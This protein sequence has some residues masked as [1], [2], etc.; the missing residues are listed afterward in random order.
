MAVLGACVGSFLNVVIYRVPAGKSVVYPGSA[1]TCGRPIAWYDNIPVISWLLLRGRARCCGRTFSFRY[2]AIE[3]L[4]AGLFLACWLHFAPAKA[5]CGW[6]LLS[7]LVAGSCID[8][9]HMIIPDRF[10]LGL[11]GVG[12]VLAVLV[13]SLHGFHSGQAVFDGARSLSVALQGLL[14]GS[15]IVLWLAL[16][17]EAVLKRE[18][19]GIG[20]VKLLGAIGVFCGWAGAAFALGAGAVIGLLWVLLSLIWKRVTGKDSALAP[21]AK[22]ADG[23]PA[24]LGRGVEIPFGPSLAVAGAIYFLCARPF[25]E[26]NLPRF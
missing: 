4:V 9:D 7:C 12:L 23:A 19:M 2:C 24:E 1:C 20:D 25:V 14:I 15:G 8:I 21:M 17:A 13:P 26:A 11:A 10:T 16:V 18:A 5:V 22:T 6:I 3:L